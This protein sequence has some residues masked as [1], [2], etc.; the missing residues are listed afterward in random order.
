MEAG[1]FSSINDAMCL[2]KK[3]H[4]R[5]E[6]LSLEDREEIV[7]A[8]RK[9]LMSHVEIMAML[10]VEETG[11]GNYP[12]KKQKLIAAIERTPAAEDLVTEVKTG[13]RGMTLYELSAFGIICT[14]EPA[15]SPAA[16]IINHVIGMIAA[17][18]AVVVCPNP[19]AVKTSNYVTSLIDRAIVETCGIDNLVV[20]YDVSNIANAKEIMHH[21]DVDMVVCNVGEEAL[22]GSFAC[23]KKV[24]GE[25][26][27][28][29]VALIDET[30]D[31]K[32]AAHDIVLSASFDYN[33]MHTSEKALVA[34]DDIEKEL[35]SELE[36]N[37]ALIIQSSDEI[38]KL[39]GLIFREDGSVS[40]KWIGKSAETILQTAGIYYEGRVKLIVVKT[41]E[42]HRFV[43]Q[44]VPAPIVPLV[45][46]E[47]YE[48]GLERMLVIEQGYKH[49]AAVHSTS[50]D[51][52]NEV[53]KKLQTAVF[54][55]NGPAL[56][57]V[58]ILGNHTPFTQMVAN[59]TG[60][61][62]VSARHYTRRRKCMLTNGFSIR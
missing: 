21:P 22:K 28:N 56:E 55:K 26:G 15:G 52:L 9:K 46:A 27:A 16:S 12:D 17:G 6:K 19:R 44:E 45:G 33:V 7:D 47:S 18:N 10:A 25:G 42:Y 40:R 60:E 36:K 5:Y 54:V 59:V 23:A 61:G 4:E 30:A 38:E 3:A 14:M 50:I 48:E 57:G 51:R 11:M 53:A 49:T 29:C 39:A 20:S 24:I 1:I 8:I 32:K 13:D 31:L 35:E 2:V 37:G 34:V 58:G 43:T 62:T 41:T